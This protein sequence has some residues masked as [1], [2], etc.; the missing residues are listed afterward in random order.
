MEAVMV[1]MKSLEIELQ[2]ARKARIDAE[3][4]SADVEGMIWEVQHFENARPKMAFFITGFDDVPIT[5]RPA[6]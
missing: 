6:S 2:H 3:A 1:D 4:A 5:A